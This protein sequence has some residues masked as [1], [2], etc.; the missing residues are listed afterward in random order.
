ML[1]SGGRER[2][3]A[4]FEEEEIRSAVMSLG[5]LKSPGLDVVTNEFFKKS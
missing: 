1:L 3:E 4:P 2:L 5:S